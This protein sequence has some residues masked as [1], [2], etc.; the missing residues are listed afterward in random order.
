MDSRPQPAD[1]IPLGAGDRTT[2]AA[3]RRNLVAL[4]PE[5]ILARGGTTVGALLQ[6]ATRTVP[7]VFVQVVDPVG[8]GFVA[9]LARPGGNATGFTSFEYGLSGKMAGAAQRDRAARNAG[10]RPVGIRHSRPGPACWAR[11]RPWRRRWR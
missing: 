1:R 6:Q 10:G 7:I 4:A 8:A 5:V 9:S 2:F 11:S 3:S